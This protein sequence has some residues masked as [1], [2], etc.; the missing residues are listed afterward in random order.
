MLMSMSTWCDPGSKVP[1]A[2]S[3]RI[4]WI[5]A[6]GSFGKVPKNVTLIFANVGVTP[7]C[8]FGGTYRFV[9]VRSK[10]TKSMPS[11]SLNAG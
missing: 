10:R 2:Y 3:L 6:W 11:G 9:F 8:G 4:N 1:T 7:G 5:W